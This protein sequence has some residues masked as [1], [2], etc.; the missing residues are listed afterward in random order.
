MGT[1]KIIVTVILFLLAIVSFVLSC[2]QF[3]EKG[4]LFNN[5]WLYASREERANMNKKPHYRQSAIVFFLIGVFFLLYAA[6]MLLATGWL[7]YAAWISM[8]AA[9]IYAIV[10]SIVS[11]VKKERAKN[12]TIF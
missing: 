10:S 7:I 5:A 8:V 4:I 11:S 12:D 6:E 9:G 2:F 1:S 3:K